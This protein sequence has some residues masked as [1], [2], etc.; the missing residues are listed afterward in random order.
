MKRGEASSAIALALAA[1]LHG[2]LLALALHA[3][4]ATGVAG[5][6][7][8]TLENTTFD[9]DSEVAAESARPSASPGADATRGGSVQRSA[10]EVA[11]SARSADR[12]PVLQ[13]GNDIG[14]PA[15]RSSQEPP[16]PGANE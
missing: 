12:E 8:A 13:P 14:P 5:A 6:T 1:L 16:A 7:I 2:A 3:V 10:A 9:V 4:P 15:A 11:R